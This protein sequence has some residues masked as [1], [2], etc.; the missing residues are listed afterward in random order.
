MVKREGITMKW[1][2]KKALWITSCL[3]L[4]VLIVG[5]SGVQASGF[6]CPGVVKITDDGVCKVLN[7]NPNGERVIALSINTTPPFA[8]HINIVETPS[9][10][11]VEPPATRENINATCM[12]QVLR[13]IQGPAIV[14]N[15]ENTYCRCNIKEGGDSHLTEN[16]S[17]TLGPEGQ[18]KL[19]C[20]FT[21]L[22]DEAE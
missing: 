1:Q 19:S 18:F 11:T 14:Y 10:P 15:F 2:V 12:G 20:H 17:Q 9:A 21:E 3:V 16:W 22:A 13:P 6:I 8:R 5:V 7:A 4:A